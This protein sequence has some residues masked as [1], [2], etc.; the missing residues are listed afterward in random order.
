[1]TLLPGGHA[2]FL[3]AALATHALVGYALGAVLFD[4]PAAGLVGGVAADVD[5]LVPAAIGEPFVHRGV[6]HSLLGLAVVTALGVRLG[7]ARAGALAVGYASQLL[8]DATT[9]MGIPLFLPV[10]GTH[11]GFDPGFG[12]HSVPASV[13]LW[14]GSLGVLW[15]ARRD[16]AGL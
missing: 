9:P 8:I 13:G 2:G 10:S 1:M 3:L 5:L 15:Y 12:G 11:V 6:T 7:R 16:E 4:R 14:I